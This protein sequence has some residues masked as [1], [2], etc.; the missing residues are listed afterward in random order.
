VA[1]L[2]NHGK[3]LSWGLNDGQILPW[4]YNIPEE[5]PAGIA[6]EIPGEIPG[7]G[8]FLKSLIQSGAG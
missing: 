3:I 2:F 6:G 1:S 5:T 4:G 7:E 8:Y